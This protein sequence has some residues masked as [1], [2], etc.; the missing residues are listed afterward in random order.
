MNVLGISLETHQSLRTWIM[1]ER[2]EEEKRL[3]KVI[4]EIFTHL[5]YLAHSIVIS[6]NA[7]GSSGE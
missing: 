2:L 5:L 7:T 4:N 6:A 3:V 1:G